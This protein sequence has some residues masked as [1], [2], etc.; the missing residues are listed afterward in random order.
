MLFRMQKICRKIFFSRFSCLRGCRMKCSDPAGQCFPGIWVKM[1]RKKCGNVRRFSGRQW[2]KKSGLC[3][4]RNMKTWLLPLIIV[5]GEGL[6]AGIQKRSCV[7]ISVA[8]WGFRPD[9][10]RLTVLWSIMTGKILQQRSIWR[11]TENADWYYVKMIQRNIVRSC[12][13]GSIILW[14]DL[15]KEDFC[16]CGLIRYRTG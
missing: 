5:W 6:A 3:R 8:A 7:S 14:N 9:W 4:R 15:K 2:M 10:I 13:T 12:P 11:M 1:W 16:V